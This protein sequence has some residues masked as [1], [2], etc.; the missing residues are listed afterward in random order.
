[1]SLKGK[2]A[3]VTG[4]TSGIGLAIAQRFAAD[5]ANLMLNGFGDQGEIEELR[6]RIEER[7]RVKC[8]YSGADMSKPAE[9]RAMVTEADRALGSVDVLVNN[10]GVQHVAPIED[11]PDEKWDLV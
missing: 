9:I 4:S 1:M 2:G 8:G 7:H 5:G 6:K 10:A 3:I 11:F